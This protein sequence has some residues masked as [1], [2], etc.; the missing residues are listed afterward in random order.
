M[1]TR[2]LGNSDLQITR[3]GY[4][5]W[6]VGGSGWQFGWGS[7]DD[8]DSI[9]AIR[10]ALELGIN[11]IDTAAVYGLGHSEDVVG[12]A[13]EGLTRED[14]IV[15]TKCGR[16]PDETGT[17]HGNLSPAS[18][19]RELE[20]SLKRLRTDYLDLYQFHWP[21]TESGTPMEESWQ[22]MADLQKEGKVR[23]IGV[24]NFE[25]PL[26]ERIEPIAH[27]D[28]LQPPYSLLRRD[29]ETEILPWCLANGTG[30]V[31]YSP[32]QAGLLSG[33]FD[34]SRV[35]EDD[36]RQRNPYFQQPRLSRNL[37]FVE[38]IRPIA[39]REGKTV[40]NLAVAWT[41]HNPAVTSAIVGARSPQQVEQNVGG[42][43]WRLSDA[44]AAEIDV[45]LK[46]EGV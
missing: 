38:R 34:M 8:N 43:G 22:A 13:I 41:L 28:S 30:V 29:V 27:I 17:P 33:T 20:V 40:G 32:M 15:A 19:R 1:Q 45:A 39:E 3:V 5:A 14:I 46:A 35:A 12:R 7:Q 18:I 11:W 31:V 24:S 23:F 42:M 4:G 21:D 6:A 10:R 16:V 25:V 26:M 36:W 9:A 2:T 44:D 37:A